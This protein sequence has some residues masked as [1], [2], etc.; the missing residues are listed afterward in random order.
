[1]NSGREPAT[2]SDSEIDRRLNRFLVQARLNGIWH[3]KLLVTVE[4]Y[5]R[6]RHVGYDWVLYNWER[7]LARKLAEK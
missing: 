1:M 5:I 2:P 4:G 7:T 6:K 3:D